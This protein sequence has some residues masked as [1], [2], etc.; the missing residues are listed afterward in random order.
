MT[1]PEPG[2]LRPEGLAR[3]ALKRP[4]PEPR[5]L[6]PE[7]V[8][9]RSRLPSMSPRSLP[10]RSFP[11]NKGGRISPVLGICSDERPFCAAPSFVPGSSYLR[12]LVQAFDL[13]A[14]VPRPGRGCAA[15]RG[16]GRC[17]YCRVPA[18]ALR[19]SAGSLHQCPWCGHWV[20]ESDDCPR[21]PDYCGHAV[22]LP[23]RP[24]CVGCED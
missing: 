21:P 5:G 18:L 11:W 3:V 17:G 8:P 4:L 7:G 23:A 22:I 6:R 24:V 13:A 1:G 2:G 16:P 20:P 14:V 12:V 9:R 15:G 19:M 10:L